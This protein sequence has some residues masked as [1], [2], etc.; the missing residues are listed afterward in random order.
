MNTVEVTIVREK[1]R[2]KGEASPEQIEKAAA[3]LD[4][5]MRSILAGNPSLPLHQ[6]AVLAALNL[7]NDYLTL[8]EEYE[9]LVKMLP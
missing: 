3:L 6:V 8:K 4:E 1:Y 2:I 7:A 5:M 9:S